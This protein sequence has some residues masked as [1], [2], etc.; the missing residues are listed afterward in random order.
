MCCCSEKKAVGDARRVGVEVAQHSRN[1]TS[2]ATLADESKME[3]MDWNNNT[4][5]SEQLTWP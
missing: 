1:V 4:E 3:D 5:R 2:P